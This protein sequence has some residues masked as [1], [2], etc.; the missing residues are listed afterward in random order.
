MGYI[1]D[2]LLATTFGFSILTF[3]AALFMLISPHKVHSLA[4]RVD[5]SISTEKY[6]NSLDKTKYIDRYFYKYHIIFGLF[7]IIGSL[8][9]IVMLTPHF[10][11]Y[12]KLPELINRAVSPW[13]YDA[14]FSTLLVLSS[15]IILI[16]IIIVIRPSA[17]KSF[18]AKMNYWKDTSGL[19]EPLDRERFLEQQKPLK[20][21]RLYGLIVLTGSLYI[22]WQTA[23]HVLNL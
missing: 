18:E 4:A 7:I 2:V 21:P 9:T 20:N 17:I 14:L 8:Y 6:F 13:L 15:F 16:G 5:V 22:L 19:I 12:Q 23:P 1:L 11:E 10:G 3:V